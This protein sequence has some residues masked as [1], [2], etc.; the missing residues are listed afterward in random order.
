M[1]IS[2]SSFCA[3]SPN[4][5]DCCACATGGASG[6][7][8][9]ST[10]AEGVG[11]AGAALG[12]FAVGRRNASAASRPMTTTPSAPSSMASVRVRTCPTRSVHAKLPLRSLMFGPRP[13]PL[14]ANGPGLVAGHS[15]NRSR[16]AG[17][18]QSDLMHSFRSHTQFDWFIGL[19]LTAGGWG[20]P[21]R[22]PARPTGGCDLGV[23]A[24]AEPETRAYPLLPAAQTVTACPRR[25][26]PRAAGPRRPGGPR[27]P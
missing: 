12:A 1:R 14:R 8:P 19:I 22:R 5:D 10:G 16:H 24:R 18:G 6:V 17:F 4:C 21:A 3:F 23:R 15:A 2:S 25:R 26:P 20:A 27:P 9:A 11:G 7:G 13:A